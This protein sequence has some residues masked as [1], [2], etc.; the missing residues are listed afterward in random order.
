MAG[1]LRCD[2]RGTSGPNGAARRF[3]PFDCA[4]LTTPI[5]RCSLRQPVMK[6][7]LIFT[8]VLT[9]LSVHA[10]IGGAE[11]I[12]KRQ[13]HDAVNQT[14]ERDRQALGQ[15]APAPATAAPKPA[16]AAQ[17]AAQQLTPQ[18]QAAYRLLSDMA[19][20]KTNAAV[21]ADQKSAMARDLTGLLQG[22]NKPSAASMN[23]LGEDLA[24][25]LAEKKLTTAQNARLYQNINALLNNSAL[26]AT[27]KQAVCDDVEKTLQVS[28]GDNKSAAAVAADLKTISAEVQKGA[29]K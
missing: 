8:A 20:I 29:A 25:A 24:S 5:G 22:A 26:P 21:T 14:T 17:P 18:Q 28:G 12:A 16:A 11:A 6:R 27:Q 10:Q 19:G 23:K 2:A 7:I 13:A 3:L 9:A 4:R 1:T 15:Q